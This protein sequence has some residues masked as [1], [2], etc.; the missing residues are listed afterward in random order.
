MHL[1][2]LYRKLNKDKG[3]TCKSKGSFL[4]RY[5][6]AAEKKCHPPITSW[7]V[8]TPEPEVLSRRYLSVKVF[9]PEREELK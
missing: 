6:K 1:K 7:I 9:C 8:C 3:N 5:H 2:Q 4:K